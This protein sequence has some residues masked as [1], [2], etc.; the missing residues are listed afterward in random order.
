MH[1]APL[2]RTVIA[3]HLLVVLVLSSGRAQDR[4]AL[5]I[6]NSSYG[7]QSLPAATTN[8]EVL[9]EALE[10]A[11][12]AVTIKENVKDFRREL[13]TFNLLCPDGG[14]SLFYYCGYANRYQRKV[15]KTV[16]QPD[17][18]KEKIESMELT[19][20]LLP[21]EKTPTER[22]RSKCCTSEHKGETA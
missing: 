2:R 22:T 15:S 16:T 10:K 12:F 17:G 14:I 20:G 13:E 6:G 9:A 19:S 5:L 11:G 7:Q 1:H 18:S 21:I 4:V 3:A 8:L